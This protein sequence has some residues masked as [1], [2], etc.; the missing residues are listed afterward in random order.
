MSAKSHT[1]VGDLMGSAIYSIDGLAT[2]AEAIELMKQH[3]VSSL[4]V[5]RRD[6]TDEVGLVVVSDIARQVIAQNH[7]PER[8]NVYEIMSKPVLTLPSDMLTSYAVRLLER[9]DISRAVVVDEDREP[10]GIITL[11]DLVMGHQTGS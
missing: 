8:V 1:T 4:I 9:F 2:V 5:N 6:H 7:S 3:N 11:R 10:L